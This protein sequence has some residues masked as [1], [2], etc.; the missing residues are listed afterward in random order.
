MS[1]C[2]D[3]TGAIVSTDGCTMVIKDS[4]G[5]IIKMMSLATM[6]VNVIGDTTYYLDGVTGWQVDNATAVSLGIDADILLPLIQECKSVDLYPEFEYVGITTT[7]Y[8]R[9]LDSKK[10]IIRTCKLEN[11]DIEIT[12]TDNGTSLTDAILASDYDAE[13]ALQ[14]CVCTE[15]EYELNEGQAVTYA[16]LLSHFE[17]T[18]TFDDGSKGAEGI[19]YVMF[20]N[21]LKSGLDFTY[22]GTS[23]NNF[24]GTKYYGLS[25]SNNPISNDLSITSNSGITT[26]TFEVYKCN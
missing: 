8:C 22:N 10:V 15:V 5:N 25:N 17:A 11:G 14:V 4:D 1:C 23:R 2:I 6:D 13:C 24:L 19:N 3:L 26:V 18:G 21:V 12:D 7:V 16:E 20:G 9:L